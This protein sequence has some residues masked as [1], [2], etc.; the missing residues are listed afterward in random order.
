MTDNQ[1]NN[2]RIA[3][4]TILLYFRMFLLFVVNF[5]MT[6]VLLQELGVEDYGLYNV[7]A[8]FVAMLGFINTSMTNS[9]QRF[10]NYQMGKGSEEGVKLFFESS[11]LA[12]LI[13]AGVV[14]FL[15]ETV[16]LW[17]L[18]YRMVIPEGRE[19]AASIIY[20]SACVCTLIGFIRAPYNALI[21]AKERMGFY[22]YVS[23]GETILKVAI[24]FALSWFAIDKLSLYGV[25]LV[26]VTL[27][28]FCCSL[29]YC[30]K[31]VPSIRFRINKEKA[32][33]KEILSFSGWNLF[34]SVS[35]TIKSQGINV[36]MNLFFGV[37]INAARGVAFQVLGGIQQFVSNFQ[38]A[39]NPQIVQSYSAGETRRY[40]QLTYLSAKISL[41][42]MWIV[43]LPILF[44]IDDI[45]L[46]W[47]GD[48][49]VPASTNLFVRIILFTGL[50]DALGS[51]LSVSLYAT[52][53]IKVYQITVSIIKIMVL[54]ISYVLYSW[55][56]A[57]ATSMYVSLVLA[58][59]EQIMR[60]VIWSKLVNE[61]PLIYLRKIVLPS[62]IVIATSVI[63]MIFLSG[64]IS[65]TTHIVRVLLLCCY[66][67][68]VSLLLIW[69]IGANR[70]E[71]TQ[72]V[73]LINSR[74][75]R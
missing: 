2:K 72:I 46:L 54:P 66:S 62:I 34:G 53:K 37:T 40:L 52:G 41:Y 28:V 4:N 42:M 47:L 56:Y 12:Q 29:L 33:L 71:R 31:I 32:V 69:F 50:F 49:R 1:Q 23:I 67:L 68:P 58:G 43:S 61:S 39:I 15:L 55:G 35:G 14:L 13:L 24:I 26:L 18:N 8:G 17:F 7:V 30:K 70:A 60:V 20:Q 10:I 75:N 64:T 16:G 5:Y 74:I 6:R 51:S 63:A 9:I 73:E 25:L 21:I 36:V 3:K 19:I 11:M 65:S 57:P 48:G 59:I 44:G 27:I 22:A 38:L 45:L